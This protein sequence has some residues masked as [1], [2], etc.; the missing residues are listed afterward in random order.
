MTGHSVGIGAVGQLGGLLGSGGQ[1]RVFSAPGAELP[2]VPGPLVYKQYRAGHAP[3]HGLASVVARRLRMDEA[4]RHRL[5]RSAAWPLRTVEEDGAVLGVLMRLIPDGYFQDRVRPGRERARTLREVQHLFIDPARSARLG[6]PVPET[7]GRLLVCRDLALVLHLLHRNDFVVGD[8]NP[9]NAVFQLD[10]RPSVMLVDC[11]SIRIRG[12]APVVRQLNAPDWEPPESTLNQATDRYKFGLF[13]L[14]CLS[15]GPFASTARDP[16]RLA[17]VLPV[18]GL[19]LLESALSTDPERRPTAQRW[20]RYFD[21]LLAE[22]PTATAPS[23]PLAT[24]GWRRDPR[25]RRWVRG[26]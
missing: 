21:A 1:A 16:G 3:P 11:D 5:D 9:M 20:G 13:V 17:G 14:R 7:A 19:A 4:V 22:W 12:A 2:D 10:G 18:E 25:T 23:R 26:A 6:M 15:P 8:I 24:T